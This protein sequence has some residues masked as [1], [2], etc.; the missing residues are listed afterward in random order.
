[1]TMKCMQALV[2]VQ[3]RVRAR[4]L[5]VAHDRFKKQFEEEEKRSAMEKPNNGTCRNDLS[6]HIKAPIVLTI[7]ICM[8]K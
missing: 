7:T 5:Q 1:M 2:R 4:R 3:G 6:I 8:V